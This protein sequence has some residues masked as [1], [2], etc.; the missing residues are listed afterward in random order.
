[1]QRW[2]IL[3]LCLSLALPVPS[4]AIF[5]VGDIVSDPLN[6]V[7]NTATALRSWISNANE[8][9]QIDNQIQSLAHEVQE[10]ARLPLSMV[11]EIE[12]SMATYNNLLGMA[13]GIGYS[14]QSSM[15]QFEAL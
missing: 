13:K 15:A 3:S 10:L 14:V 7:Q 12:D 6:L 5:G 2:I 8:I 9:L 11:Q 4:F 1:M